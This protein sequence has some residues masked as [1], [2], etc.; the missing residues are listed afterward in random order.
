MEIINAPVEKIKTNLVVRKHG[1]M[2]IDGMMRSIMSH[3]LLHPI[4]LTRDYELVYGWRRLQ[5]CQALKVETIPA[6]FIQQDDKRYHV[7][8]TE[9]DLREDLTP[10]EKV[11]LAQKLEAEIKNNNPALIRK[12]G[13]IKDKP[14]GNESSES[15]SA[16]EDKKHVWGNFPKHVHEDKENKPVSQDWENFPNPDQSDKETRRPDDIAAKDAGLGNRRSYH[17]A[18]T[19]VNQGS[20]PLKDAMNQNKISIDAAFQLSKL[21]EE[22]QAAINYDDKQ[23]VKEKVRQIRKPPEKSDMNKPDINRVVKL[24]SDWPEEQLLLLIEALKQRVK[25]K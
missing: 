8:K 6:V 24:T 11:L 14:S 10:E 23:A 18:E 25:G 1:G 12:L 5:A 20:Q 13:I 9:N 3:G 4:G 21:P 19:V 7:M 2:D 17:K 22:E 16:E 15:E